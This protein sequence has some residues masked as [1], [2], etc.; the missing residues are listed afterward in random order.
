MKTIRILLFLKIVCGQLEDEGNLESIFG[1]A[2]ANLY[3]EHRDL[4]F[5][6]RIILDNPMDIEK[7]FRYLKFIFRF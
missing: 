2:D 4:D 6:T 3:F 1:Q 5:I 7:G